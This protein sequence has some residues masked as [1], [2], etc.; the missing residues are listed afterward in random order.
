MELDVADDGGGGCPEKELAAARQM[1]DDYKDFLAIPGLYSESDY[2]IYSRHLPVFGG[3]D[4]PA[5]LARAGANGIMLTEPLDPTFQM[6]ASFGAYY[7]DTPHHVACLFHPNSDSSGDWNSYQKVLVSRMAQYGMKFRDIIVY[8]NDLSTAQ[9]QSNAMV[10]RAK[11]DGCDQG[12]L[13]SG[14]PIAW[15]F[16]TQAATANLWF[17][18]WTFTSY[19][20][21]ADSD[22]A[23]GLMDQRQ[24]ANAVG[25]SS[26]VPSGQNPAEGNCAKIYQRYYPNDGQSGSV[27]VQIA[28]AQIMSVAEIMR[29]AVIR[30]GVLTAD[31]L[32]LGADSI[33]NDFWYDATVPLEWDFPGSSGPFKTKAFSDLTVARWDSTQHKYLFPTYPT[34]WKVMGPHQSQGENLSS[35]WRSYKPDY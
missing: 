6:W 17:P 30:T 21:L 3:R 7:L 26:R 25:L 18:T 35:T 34:Y 31:S 10:A 16:I 9:Q 13:L 14:N 22:L 2:L 8:N 15:I 4:D 19:S 5:S 29:H 11:A 12:W 33:K 24:W 20:V 23:G 1:A 28:C 32:L 27:A